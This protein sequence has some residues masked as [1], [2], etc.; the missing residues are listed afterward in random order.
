MS[1]LGNQHDGGP[2]QETTC[3]ALEESDLA[4]GGSNAPSRLFMEEAFLL[5]NPPPPLEFMVFQT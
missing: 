1:D 2:H 5:L 3:L 4:V